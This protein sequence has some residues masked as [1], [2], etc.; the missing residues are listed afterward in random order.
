MKKEESGRKRKLVE[1][2]AEKKRQSSMKKKRKTANVKIPDS[3]ACYQDPGPYCRSYDSI[4]LRIEESQEERR[5]QN[6]VRI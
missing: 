5:K 1:E 2:E 4:F 3:Q 6:R